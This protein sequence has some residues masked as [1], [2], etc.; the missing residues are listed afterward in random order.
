MGDR[1]IKKR[2]CHAFDIVLSRA[3]PRG[4]GRRGLRGMG[5]CYA[6]RVPTHKDVVQGL[7]S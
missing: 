4:A 3:M 6:W 2:C 7:L 5:E 1:G